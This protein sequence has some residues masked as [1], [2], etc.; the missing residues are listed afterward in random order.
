[1]L[2]FCVEIE[3]VQWFMGRSDFS[4]DEN[5]K[6]KQDVEPSHHKKIFFPT[7]LIA[8]RQKNGRRQDF[9]VD[10]PQDV[11][12]SP[13]NTFVL[14]FRKELVRVGRQSDQNGKQGRKRNYTNVIKKK[15][16][17]YPIRQNQIVSKR[18]FSESVFVIERCIH[19]FYRQFYSYLF[20]NGT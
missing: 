16:N 5:P 15:P 9:D 17:E 3:R 13:S 6:Q 2:F 7:D 8:A 19:A 10:V 1:M 20:K 12:L 18:F 4:V 14:L 11:I